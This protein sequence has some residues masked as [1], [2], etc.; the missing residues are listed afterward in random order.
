[1]NPCFELFVEFLLSYVY[2]LLY[3]ISAGDRRLKVQQLYSTLVSSLNLRLTGPIYLF[4]GCLSEPI[5]D[6]DVRL[7]SR[8]S[9]NV[10]I[11]VSRQVRALRYMKNIT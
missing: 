9:D 11:Q 3:G 2:I 1:M 10:R 8:L 7:P 5:H 4:H 6:D